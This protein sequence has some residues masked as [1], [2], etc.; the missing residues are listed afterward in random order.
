MNLMTLNLWL[1]CVAKL[2]FLIA[3]SG[4]ILAQQNES[5]LAFKTSKPLLLEVQYCQCKVEEDEKKNPLSR[6]LADTRGFQ[7]SVAEN[8]KGFV[9]FEHMAFGYLVTPGENEETF[10]LEFVEEYSLGENNS[11]TE[12]VILLELD[13]WAH[14]ASFSKESDQGNGYFNVGVRLRRSSVEGQ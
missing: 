7:V 9:Y 1:K 12:S 11:F 2:T 14:V 8:D 10:I 5:I 13:R 4:E 3:L 6:T